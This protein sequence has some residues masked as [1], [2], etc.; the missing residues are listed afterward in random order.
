MAR[1]AAI[2][3]N[4]GSTASPVNEV[5]GGIGGLGNNVTTLATLQ[6]RLA[7]ADLRASAQRGLPGLIASIVAID[8]TLASTTVALMGVGHWLADQ[9]ALSLSHALLIAGASG[10]V[11]SVVL[12]L[13][14][15]YQLRNSFTT[16]RRSREELERNIAWLGTILT[17][18]GR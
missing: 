15:W 14:A 8:L 6:A 11:L 5:L 2:T 4:S 1:E 16:F 18:S 10:I 9:G 12:L 3:D 17:Q 13:I 7:A